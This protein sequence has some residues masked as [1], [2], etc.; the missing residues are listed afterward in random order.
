MV[1]PQQSAVYTLESLASEHGVHVSR[2]GSPSGRFASPARARAAAPGPKR[3]CGDLRER[4][5]ARPGSLEHPPPCSPAQPWGTLRVA[6]VHVR[7]NAIS[8]PDPCR[9]PAP[10]K[11]AAADDAG[12][13][14]LRALRAQLAAAAR[15]AAALPLR[16][17]GRV[18]DRS[19]RLE[20][21]VRRGCAAARPRLHSPPGACG[22]AGGT[23]YMHFKMRRT[24]VFTHWPARARTPAQ[25]AG[26]LARMELA[27]IGCC[28]AVLA[29]HRPSIA[30]RMAAI[31][32]ERQS[33]ARL[34]KSS[35]LR[36]HPG[37]RRRLFAR[38]TAT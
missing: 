18:S 12:A 28:P 37:P 25:M 7:P 21:K 20:S 22:A 3:R 33:F 26:V 24:H 2:R 36:R 27:G 8:S 29:G 1:A 13:R 32:G 16:L 35:F 11:G 31:Q 15:L 10:A 17:R 30:A 34:A 23:A 4:V 19:M 14:P 5:P 38:M 9:P 6:N